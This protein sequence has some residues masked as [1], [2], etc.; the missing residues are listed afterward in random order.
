[1]NAESDIAGPDETAF[2]TELERRSREIDE[3]KAE[4]ISWREL[5]K[6]SF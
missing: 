2:A 1:M 5:K 6:E 4:L 3:A